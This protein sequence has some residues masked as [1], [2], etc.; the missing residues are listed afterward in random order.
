MTVTT[1]LFL[2]KCLQRL[3]VGENAV[4]EFVRFLVLGHLEEADDLLQ[5]SMLR[6]W[7][8]LADVKPTTVSEFMG[9]AALQMRRSLRDLARKHFGRRSES[10]SSERKSHQLNLRLRSTMG[11]GMTVADDVRNSPDVMLSW[12]EFHEAADRLPQPE[13]NCFDLMYYHG[14][15]Q[16][17][18]AELMNV[19]TRQVARYWQSA[20]RKVLKAMEGCWPDD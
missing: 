6:L 10:R 4:R 2:Q 9:L 5:E 3:H 1:T 15:P 17:E 18:V 13:R 20:R 11:Q 14:L 8:S 7:K 16:S 19:S 12:S